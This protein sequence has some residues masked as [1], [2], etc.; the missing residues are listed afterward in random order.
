MDNFNELLEQGIKAL[1][2]DNY[3]RALWFLDKAIL[4]NPHNHKAWNSLGNSLYYLKRYQ[5]ALISFE[6]SIKIKPD[7]YNPWN[8]R[9]NALRE[10]GRCKEAIDSYDQS[11]RLNP[12]DREPWNGRGN[13]LYDLGHYKEAID[14]Y[15]QSIKLSSD[16][17]NPWNGR[18]NALRE[19]GH[20][21]E[22]IDSY[23][24]SIAFK[25]DYYN[26]WNGRGNALY[27]LG[28]YKEAID[29]YN[30][31]I[32]FKPDYYNP[33]NGRGNALY[34]LGH[35]KEAIDSYNQSIAFKPDYCDPWNGLGNALREL[36][37]YKE[38]IDSYNQSIKLEPNYC[39]P[40]TGRGNVLYDLGQYRESISSYERSIALK[41]DYCNP[42]NGR[43]NALR[44]LGLYQEAMRSY[45][46]AIALKSDYY[47]S[48]NGRGNVFYSLKDYGEAITCY[49]QAIAYSQGQFWQAWDN[50]GLAIL[51]LQGDDKLAL[52]VWDEG[53]QAILPDSSAYPY[54]IAMLHRRKAKTLYN[55]SQNQP[56]P[57]QN[58]LRARENYQKAIDL[59]PLLDYPKL[60]LELWQDFLKICQQ[61]GDQ[62]TIQAA[63]QEASAK[64][65]RLLDDPDRSLGEKI[66]LERRFESFKQIQIDS[67]A[68]QDP[69]AAIELAETCKNRCLWRLREDWKA[70]TPNT[71][72][73][74]IQSLLN[75]T[76][77]AIYW[78]RSPAAI[79][80]FIL[81]HNQPPKILPLTSPKTS[82]LKPGQQPY[83]AA[84]HQLAQ[85]EAWLQQ[86]TALYQNY[87]YENGKTDP[88]RQ[89]MELLLFNKL[90]KILEINSLCKE[91]QPIQTLILIPHRDLHL[92]PLQSLFP[93]KFRCTMLPSARLALDHL[94]TSPLPHSPT[95]T[96]IEDPPTHYTKRQSK[97]PKKMLYAELES[98]LISTFFSTH[99]L[100]SDQATRTALQIHLTQ[101]ADFFHFTGHAYH[102]FDDPLD[103]ALALAG[104]EL[105][106]LRDIF[107]LNLNPY[108]LVCLSACETGLTRQ[109]DLTDEYVGLVA[110]FLKAGVN[111]VI[112]TLWIVD[113]ISSALFMIRLYEN[114]RRSL[115]PIDAFRE[116]QTWLKSDYATLIPWYNALSDRLPN[117]SGHAETLKDAAHLALKDAAIKGMSHRPFEHP[118]HWAGFMLT[119]YEVTSP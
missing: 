40:W 83:P 6:Q 85:F 75:E 28:H 84:A 105:L 57:F 36:G 97:T 21:K 3:E 22:A 82:S 116:A 30:Q 13:A 80:T 87:N 92:L 117:H 34:D 74:E 78:H 63:L 8:G 12:D 46:Q 99:S 60:H 56:S 48:W 42:W 93:G 2:H 55:S 53:I 31:S 24:Q 41:P 66:S 95:L 102:N 1:E 89:N 17:Y 59:L 91:L 65:Q 113:E 52:T 61:L 50:R 16:Y 112:S 58:W 96:S 88:W 81:H 104:T 72:Y 77:A 14:S 20:Y 33:W 44:E 73:T 69:I 100:T 35:Y 5:K 26:P 111:F 79:T 119:G 76:T 106:T 86:W 10:L 70:S 32:A 101:P 108:R 103:S 38:A 49:D 9:G 71:S 67:L 115:S 98:T 68:Q 107:Q 54:G 37:R 109:R 45:K 43:G 25:P 7:S 64:L 118:Y 94:P 114:L 18:G 19:L 4:L 47:Y 110:G 90:R 27:D 11:I 15:N 39:Q 51:E 62:R 29:S 23:N